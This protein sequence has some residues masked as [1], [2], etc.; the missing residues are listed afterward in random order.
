MLECLI[1]GD[2]I[3]VGM[4]MV[5]KECVSYSKGGLNTWQ[6]N[7]RYADKAL[8]PA[9]TVIISL[10]TNDHKGIKTRTELE[11]TRAR[12]KGQR[13]YWIMPHDNLYPAGGVHISVIQGIVTDIA[14]KYGDIVIGTKRY[15]KDNIHPSWAGYKELADQTR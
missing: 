3:A 2:S 4:E 15:Q 11:N 8:G 14:A 1:I 12:I 13:V 9:G 10:G 5:R 6:W 7:K